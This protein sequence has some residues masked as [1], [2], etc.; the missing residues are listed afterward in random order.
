MEEVVVRTF[1]YGKRGLASVP[2]GALIVNCR[3]LPNV[4][5]NPELRHVSGRHARILRWLQDKYPLQV[6]YL[7]GCAMQA[8]R[9]EGVRVVYFGCQHGKHRSVAMAREF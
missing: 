6:E 1:V 8:V 3:V 4:W 9:D 5:R 7:L 2:G